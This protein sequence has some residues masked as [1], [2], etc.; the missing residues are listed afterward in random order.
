MIMEIDGKWRF[1]IGGRGK[2]FLQIKDLPDSYVV[3]DS[4]ELGID[5]KIPLWLF[6]FMY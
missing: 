6:G 2:G 3:S 5:H 4:V 1:E